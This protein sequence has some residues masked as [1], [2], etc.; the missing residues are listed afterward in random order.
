[1]SDLAVLQENDGRTQ[2]VF[3][4][5]LAHAQ[6]TVWRAVSDPDQHKAWFPG[7]MR[8]AREK[9]ATL[10]F[11]E[12]GEPMFSGEMLVF[13]PPSV[14]EFSWGPDDIVRIEVQPAGSGSVLTLTHTFDE[15]GKAAR[16]GA[17]WHECLDFLE[18]ALDGRSA[19]F[20]AGQRW[21]EIHPRYVKAFGPAAATIGPPEGWSPD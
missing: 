10:D 9:G 4:R 2:L 11:V 15:L 18:C 21:G 12:K 5:R 8:G 3:T 19:P 20:K 16:D 17:G 6:D 14:M 1:M 13:D 7:E